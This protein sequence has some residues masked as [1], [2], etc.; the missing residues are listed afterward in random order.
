M[1]M[2]HGDHLPAREQSSLGEALFGK[3]SK[4]NEKIYDR[5]DAFGPVRPLTQLEKTHRVQLGEATVYF[6][7]GVAASH[8]HNGVSAG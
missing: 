4:S 2:R 5:Y 7:A 3:L 6:L 1:A 8:Q